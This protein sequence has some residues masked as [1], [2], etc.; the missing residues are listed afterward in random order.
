MTAATVFFPDDP[1]VLV[2]AAG[3]IGAVLASGL[4]AIVVAGRRRGRPLTSGVLFLRW[5]TWLVAAPLYLAA[6]AWSPWTA[7]GF[8]VALSVQAAREYSDVVGLARPYRVALIVA[9]ATA[10]AALLAGPDLWPALPPFV[11]LAAT[12]LPLLRQDVREGPRHLAFAMLGFVLVPWTLGFLFLIRQQIPGGVRILFSI[13]L[14]VALSDVLAFL[15]GSAAGRR[16][17]QPDSDTPVPVLSRKLAPVLSPAKT[18]AG[19]LGNLCGAFLG[20]WLL[21]PILPG[22]LP[23][24]AGLCMPAVIAAAAVWGDLVESLLKR[25]GGVKDAGNCL[26][27]FGGLLDRIDSLLLVLPASYLLLGALR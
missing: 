19:V 2:P 26:P 10:P 20:W 16:G 17:P 25:F 23:E 6:I 7:L 1:S 5:R 3:R 15:V 24:I 13:G 11:L 9:S 22:W 8:V 27:G 18:R 21:R 14:A 12:L 4:G